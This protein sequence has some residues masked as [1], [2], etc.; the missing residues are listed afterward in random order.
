MEVIDDAGYLHDMLMYLN[1]ESIKANRKVF[2]GHMENNG[3]PKH[4]AKIL[5]AGLKV[6]DLSPTFLKKLFRKTI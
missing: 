1:P 5:G 3:V 4:L 2:V 6:Y